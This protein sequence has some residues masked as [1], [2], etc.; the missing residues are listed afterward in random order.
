MVY[1][2]VFVFPPLDRVPSLEGLET[3]NPSTVKP[4]PK[5]LRVLRRVKPTKENEE[6]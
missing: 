2:L 3:P 4:K 5:P 1:P 6:N